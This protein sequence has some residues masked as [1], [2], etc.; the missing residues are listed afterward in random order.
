MSYFVPEV[1]MTSRRPKTLERIKKFKRRREV[2]KR[3]P[4]AVRRG[5]AALSGS[6]L[7]LH[8]IRTRNWQMYRRVMT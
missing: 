2:P 4:S 1:V 7:R 5:I 8:R 6:T 3:S